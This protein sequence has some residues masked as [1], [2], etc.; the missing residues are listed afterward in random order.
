MPV[1]DRIS[2][3]V[4]RVDAQ[5]AQEQAKE[6][7]PVPPQV[8]ARVRRGR[9]R[10][11]DGA[12]ERS[13][14]LHFWRGHQYVYR[15]PKGYLLQQD[16]VTDHAN[17]S[18]KPPHRI[19]TARNLLL[20][21]VAQEV[22]AVTS[23]VPSFQVNPSSSDEDDIAAA[24]VAEKILLYG[25]DRWD[26]RDVAVRA[27]THAILNGEAYAWPYFD[28]TVGPFIPDAEGG[29]RVGQGEVKIRV[30]GGNQVAWEAGVKFS[31]S[32]WHTVEVARSVDDVRDMEGFLGGPLTPDADSDAYLNK[33]PGKPSRTEQV[34]VTDY[35][36]R[37]SPKHPEGRWLTIANGRVIAGKGQDGEGY[38][39][40]PCRNGK[41]E[42][43]DELVL[44][45]LVYFTDPDNDRDHGLGR[46]LIDPQRS[47]NDCVNKLLEWKNL[48]P[49]GQLFVTPG[50]MKKQRLT[51]APGAVYEIPQ[52]EQNVKMREA[53]PFPDG[54]RQIMEMTQGDIARIAA[55]NDIPAQVESGR[56]IESLIARD[57]SRKATFLAGVAEW[58]SRVG[59]HCLYLVQQ[60]YGEHDDRLL[61]FNGWTGPDLITGFKGAD[62]RS[63]ADVSVS[64]SSIERLSR[65][66]LERR[67]MGYANLGWITPEA[68]MSAIAGGTA[69]NLVKSY[70]LDVARAWGVIKKIKAGPEVLLSEGH[71]FL[72]AQMAPPPPM[73][74]QPGMES[75]GATY[76]VPG[77][78][79]PVEPPVAPEQAPVG[80]DGAPFDQM[81]GQAPPPPA[82]MLRPP[83]WMPRK[84]DNL[85]VHKSVFEDYMK[86]PDYDFA[87]EPVKEAANLYYDA[88][89]WLE[90]EKQAKDAA[91]QAAQ[92]E[93]YGMQNAAAPQ[94]GGKSNPSFPDTAG[95]PPRPG[96]DQPSSSPS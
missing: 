48:A 46:H 70:E 56:G 80:P 20:D 3:A 6:E 62:L 4:E 34:M 10:R 72:D 49:I 73:S 84:F 64:T 87:E 47:Y 2:S 88:L 89:E 71:E 21:V 29:S 28:N 33:G 75:Q 17:Q 45:P 95:G 55:Q 23:R 94:D 96:S 8:E 77:R 57:N 30:F 54:I 35:L 93:S 83:S 36:E 1:T 43:V 59:R 52:P 32:S 65:E 27:A 15:T 68:A 86:T 85:R 67:V 11:N 7:N 19:R 69:E 44:H 5:R 63:Q 78:D 58:W 26:M 42:V 82:P 16:T 24:K 61:R 18:G 40:Y 31:E 51:D 92:A 76:P 74:P 41:G 91:A 60:H 13:E 79:A 12:A 9:E 39:A 90:S 38:R 37:P 14:T 22:S 25:Y 50:L 53:P 81:G 66:D